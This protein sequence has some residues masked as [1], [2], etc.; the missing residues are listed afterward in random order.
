MT[1]RTIEPIDVS[2]CGDAEKAAKKTADKIREIAETVGH[3][4]E[5]EVLCE[6][7]GNRWVVFY[8]AGPYEWAIK[9]TGGLGIFGDNPEIK[10]LLD[11]DNFHVECEYSFG[12]AFYDE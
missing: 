7:R 8:E 9:L 4:P 2:D 11:A 1:D 6:Q 10:G 5:I 12:L 3:N